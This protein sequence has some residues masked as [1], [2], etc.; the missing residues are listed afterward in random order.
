MVGTPRRTTRI[1]R[2]LR[3]ATGTTGTTWAATTWTAGTTWAA[4]AL[5][6]LGWRSESGFGGL[7]FFVVEF[8][9]AVFVETREDF[10]SAFLPFLLQFRFGGCAFG[11]VDFAVAIFVEFFP[12]VITFLAEMVL[13]GRAHGLAFIVVEFPIPVRVEF[14][15]HLLA[16]GGFLFPQFGPGFVEFFRGQ[17]AILVGIMGLENGMPGF[18]WQGKETTP[19][20]FVPAVLAVA[21]AFPRCILSVSP[22]FSI[23][24]RRRSRGALARRGRRIAFRAG[25]TGLGPGGQGKR[26]GQET[27]GQL[28]LHKA[29]ADGLSG[30]KPRTTAPVAQDQGSAGKRASAGKTLIRK[31]RH[32]TC[33]PA[34]ASGTACTWRAMKP[35]FSASSVKSARDSPLRKVR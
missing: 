11:V 24:V 34:S 5:T 35:S 4:A 29:L 30:S 31:L 1:G 10:P 12:Q 22:V 28:E 23:A 13:P 18:R 8:S 14:R 7:F 21:T 20:A 17:F 15:D 2:R 33:F 27:G 9:V 6:A 25:H 16:M 3:R 26:E 32:I 19:R